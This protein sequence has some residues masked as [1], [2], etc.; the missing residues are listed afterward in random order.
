MS[1]LQPGSLLMSWSIVQ[2]QLGSV[3][4]VTLVTSGDHENHHGHAGLALPFAG[5]GKACPASCWTSQQER[6]PQHSGESW[7]QPSWENWPLFGRD[8]PIPSL[9][10]RKN[11]PNGVGLGELTPPLPLR[12]VAPVTQTYQLSYHPGPR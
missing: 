12:W 9:R 4:S 7:P 5:S 8:G 6:W 10:V 2:L 1:L 3:L 11:H